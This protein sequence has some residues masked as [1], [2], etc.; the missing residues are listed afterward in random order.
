[1][2]KVFNEAYVV[3]GTSIDI[4]IIGFAFDPGYIAQ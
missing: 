4:E 3:I 2:R 1:V